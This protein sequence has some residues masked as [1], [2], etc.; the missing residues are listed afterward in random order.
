MCQCD[1][2]LPCESCPKGKHNSAWLA[3]GCKRGELND[4]MPEIKLCPLHDP[5]GPFWY[6]TDLRGGDD[7]T[8]YIHAN[9][10]SRLAIRR[11]QEALDNIPTHGL[12]LFPETAGEVK[13]FLQS[14]ES[15]YPKHEDFSQA[16]NALRT[17][18]SPLTS[19][20]SALYGKPWT[21]LSSNRY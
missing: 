13:G 2:E 19:V 5:V 17:T 15:L 12:S 18:L 16:G 8:P 9:E 1:I 3:L 20:Y 14:L 4:E 11:R 21:V 10:C 6:Q 7:M